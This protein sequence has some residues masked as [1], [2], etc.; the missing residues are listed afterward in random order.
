MV[1][2]GAVTPHVD[3]RRTLKRPFFA[4]G[5]LAFHRAAGTVRPATPVFLA[6]PT[7]ET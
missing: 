2:E 7:V 3:H 4:T 1:K 5:Y 6:V